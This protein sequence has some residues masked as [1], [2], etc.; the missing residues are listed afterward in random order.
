MD[1]EIDKKQPK[2]RETQ[3][4]KRAAR[5]FAEILWQQLLSRKHAKS[6]GKSVSRTSAQRDGTDSFK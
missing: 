2:P 1:N 6:V 3:L 5:Q 4:T